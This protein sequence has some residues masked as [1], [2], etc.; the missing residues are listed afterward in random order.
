M[1]GKIFTTAFVVLLG[2]CNA[3][4]GQESVNCFLEDFEPRQAVIPVSEPAETTAAEPTVTV[5]ISSLDTLG[6][7]SKYI[8]GNAVAVWTGNVLTDPVLLSHLQ[9]LSPALIRYP[10]GSWSDIFFWDGKAVDVPSALINASTGKTEA[11]SPALGAGSWTT[12]LD[13]YYQMCKRVS[14]QGLITINYGYARYGIGKKPAEQA[15][16]YAADWVRYDRGRTKFWEIGN[17]SGGP[18]EAGWQIDT[19]LNRDGQP[20]IITGE[21]YGRHFRIFAD[22]MR[23]AAAEM[24]TVVYI[25]GQILHFDGTNSWNIADRKWNEGFF[26]AAEGAADFYVIHNYFGNSDDA[27]SF[28]DVASTAPRQM[29]DFIQKDII[30]KQASLKPIALT[31]WNINTSSSGGDEPK[32][33]IINGIQAVVVFCELANLNYGMSSRWLIA[34]WEGD[35]MFYRGDQSQIP[36]WNPRPDFFYL[37]YLQRFMGDHVVKAESGQRD[38]LAYASVF[39][40]GEMGVVV[41]NK[42]KT[43]QTVRLE[44]SFFQ[45]GDRFYVYSLTGGNDHGDFSQTVYVNGNGPTG[46]AWGPIQ[47]LET[48]PALAYPMGD[49]IRFASPARSV[50][51]ILIENDD[52]HSGLTFNLYQN[53]PNPFNLRTTILF[54]LPQESQ[55]TLKVYDVRGR[56]VATLINDERKEAGIHQ[57]SI[58]ASTL[59]IGIYL[60][61]LRTGTFFGTLKMLLIR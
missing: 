42:A 10:G 16:H 20:Q 4:K 26:K 22:S 11:F 31:E 23:A 28:L 3:V 43:E 48:I 36:A 52:S 29:M 35:G 55:V 39:H 37:Y 24:G 58:D 13:S 17:E 53:Y 15:A 9:K 61:G 44:S 5:F 21:L 46:Q 57:V 50:Q 34:N 51:F 38:L 47:N 40:S 19:K 18:W 6:R 49:E 33:S 27:R 54:S 30:R 59:P 8:F 7:V 41:V 14:T 1:K 32:I 2:L 60:C 45:F 12:T 25:G 56:M